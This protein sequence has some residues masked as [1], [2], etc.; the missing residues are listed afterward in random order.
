VDIKLVAC[1]LDGTLMGPDLSFS[2]RLLETIRQARKRG[3]TVTVATGRGYPSTRHFAA[4]LGIRA[5]VICYQG[6]QIR[7]RGGTVLHES[8]LPRKYLPEVITFCR[9]ENRELTV[10]YRDEIYQATWLYDQAYYDRW[11]GLPIHVVDDLMA[12]IPGEPVKFIA[13]GPTEET[14]DVL[15]R[16]L[17]S[18]AAGRFQVVR[19]HAWFVEGLG[20]GTSKGDGLA[21]L[22]Q[23]LGVAREQVMALGDSGNDAS[24]VAWAGWGVA[25]G[26]ASPEVKAVAEVIA[27]SL[28]EDGA[29]WAIARYALGEEV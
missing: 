15:E 23:R 2:S 21:R 12:A 7:G 25:M 6:A 13:I 10:Y 8:T 28:E 5:P 29:A 20:S 14:A 18:L 24:M 4:Q 1:D 22:A 16:D 11:F 9:E 26:N 3:L 17:K 19:S 27:P